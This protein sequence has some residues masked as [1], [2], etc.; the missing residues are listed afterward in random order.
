MHKRGPTKI[1]YA[2]GFISKYH[3]RQGDFVGQW[4]LE[5]RQ[6]RALLIDKCG[7]NDPRSW[8]LLQVVAAQE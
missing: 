7:D 8:D 5:R 6:L 3:R 2:L 1:K 4:G